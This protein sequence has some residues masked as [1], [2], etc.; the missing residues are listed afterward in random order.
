M[1][2]SKNEVKET[3]SHFFYYIFEITKLNQVNSNFSPVK[4]YDW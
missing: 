1:L 3:W 2:E 4:V